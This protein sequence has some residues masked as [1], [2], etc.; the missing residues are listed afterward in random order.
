M[1]VNVR[2]VAAAAGVSVGTVSNVLNRPDRVSPA[3]VERVQSVIAELG[4]VRNDAARQL[5][6]GRSRAIGLVVLDTANPF[7]A[8]VAKGAESAAEQSGHAVIVGSS[9]ESAER[10]AGL[11]GLFEEQRVH[12]VLLSPVGD[13]SSSIRSLRERGIGTVLV[14]RAG[15]PDGVS[16]VS[17]DDVDGGAQAAA[18]LVA[19]GCRRIAFLSGPD[20]LLQVADRWRGARDAVAGSPGVVL[21]RTPAASLD[22]AGGRRA[23]EALLARRGRDLP[24]GLFAGNDLMAIGALQALLAAGV[25]VPGEVAIVGYD[26]IGFASAAA[27]PLTSMRQ[28]SRRIGETAVRILLEE[29]ADPALPPRHVEFSPAL[30]ARESTAT[31]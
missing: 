21:E 15:G 7:F 9:S 8:E 11:L 25:R 10:E 5:R 13:V 26:D 16:S 1:P 6:A 19:R 24:D 31:G 3:T 30:V 23:A 4:F 28:P 29:A 14:D 18:H 12:G 22:I 2:D 27:V 20:G 17:V